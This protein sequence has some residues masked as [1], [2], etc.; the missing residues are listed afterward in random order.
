MTNPERAQQMWSLLA[1]AAISR[2]VLTYDIVARLTGLVRYGVGNALEPIQQYCSENGLPALTV[3]VVSDVG[4]PGDGFIAA[5]NVPEE[6]QRVFRHPWL[7][8]KVPSTDQLAAARA[9][10]KNRAA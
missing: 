5:S 8:T 7:D 6:Q 2:Q 10:G 4:V 3:L 9:R 1:L